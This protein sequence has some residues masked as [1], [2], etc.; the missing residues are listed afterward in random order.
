M[1]AS[2]Q[3]PQTFAHS[4]HNHRAQGKKKSL[5]DGL[6]IL[7]VGAGIF[8]I[9]TAY[10]LARG[11]NSRITILDRAKPPSTTAASTDISKIV[12]ADYAN[13]F[14]MELGYKL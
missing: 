7:I 4:S 9:S 8:G 1:L 12:R 13:P 11:G 5:Q 6:E 2:L 14:Y 10:H 3:H